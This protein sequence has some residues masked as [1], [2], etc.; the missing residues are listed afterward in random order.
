MLTGVI[1]SLYIMGIFITLIVIGYLSNLEDFD[2]SEY[3]TVSRVF[4]SIVW[5]FSLI[6]KLL[7]NLGNIS[8][9]IVK[10]RRAAKEADQ[11]WGLLLDSEK[12]RKQVQIENN[13]L[14][15]DYDKMYNLLT[16]KQKAKVIRIS[17]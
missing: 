13:K 16:T 14:K 11:I 7:L 17:K 1:I 2:D 8:N 3:A 12:Q 5:P 6:I 10:K 4:V 15:A 9:Y